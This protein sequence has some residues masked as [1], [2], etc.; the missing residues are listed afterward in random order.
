MPCEA[1]TIK[2]SNNQTNK[3]YTKKQFE[4]KEEKKR[5][6][7][8]HTKEAQAGE[9]NKCDF[10]ISRSIKHNTAEQRTDDTGPF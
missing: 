2:Q 9:N 6:L 10:E 5:K 1:N 7:G 8:G 4:K 3:K